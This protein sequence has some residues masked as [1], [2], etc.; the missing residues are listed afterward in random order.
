MFFR[1]RMNTA[2]TVSGTVDMGL[3]LSPLLDNFLDKFMAGGY[4][5]FRY[6]SNKPADNRIVR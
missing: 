6:R 1:Y 5:F 4:M 2:R 3:S